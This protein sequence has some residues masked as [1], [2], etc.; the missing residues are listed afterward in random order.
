MRCPDCFG[1]TIIKNG[2]Q[3]TNMKQKY[4]CK[5]CGRQFVLNPEKQPISD[6]KKSLVDK[7]LLE[8]LSMAGI[9]PAIGVSE[10]WLQ[11]YVND[12]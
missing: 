12:K 2:F 10:R 3:K 8:K 5:D 1:K 11:Y 9:C 4:L 6:D 7:L